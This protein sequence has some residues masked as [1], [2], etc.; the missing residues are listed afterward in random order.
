MG[1]ATG[2]QCGSQG[3]GP[4][5]GHGSRTVT[6]SQGLGGSFLFESEYKHLDLPLCPTSPPERVLSGREGD[7]RA[8]TSLPRRLLR[9][10]PP[11]TSQWP[12]AS[13]ALG[14]PRADQPRHQAPTLSGRSDKCLLRRVGRCTLAWQGRDTLFPHGPR[15]RGPLPV[16]AGHGQ[17]SQLPGVRWRVGAPRDLAQLQD[18][19][20]QD[21]SASRPSQSGGNKIRLLSPPLS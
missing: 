10:P 11:S 1:A 17:P 21:S 18:P 9:V 20:K 3:C 4:W 5:P 7:S 12:R 13:P 6:S 16:G 15:E 19:P 14:H 2:T 8:Y